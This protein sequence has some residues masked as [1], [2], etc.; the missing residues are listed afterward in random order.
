MF[1][2]I[3]NPEHKKFYEA[4]GQYFYYLQIGKNRPRWE[5]CCWYNLGRK[6]VGSDYRCRS[7]KKV[8]LPPLK[9]P[10]EE[11]MKKAA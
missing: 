3:K 4:E 8:L 11:L 2:H 1:R 6:D 10:F 7:C 5:Q 9:E